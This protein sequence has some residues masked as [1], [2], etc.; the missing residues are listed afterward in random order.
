MDQ[1]RYGSSAEPLRL[2]FPPEWDPTLVSAVSLTVNDRDGDELKAAAN[3]TLWTA[4]TLDG[5]VAA[6]SETITLA[7]GADDLKKGDE[8]LLVGAGGQETVR[9]KGWDTSTKIATLEQVVKNAYDDGDNVYGKFGTYNLDISTVATYTNGIVLV[10]IWTPTGH[11]DALTTMVQV[12]K[13]SL[14]IAGLEREFSQ[15][16]ERA[17]KAFTNPENR[18][19]AIA[20]M[21][22]RKLGAWMDTKGLDIQRVVD[23]SV[24]IDALMIEMACLWTVNGDEKIEDERRFLYEER[25]RIYRTLEGRT[26]WTDTDMDQIEEAGELNPPKHRFRDGW[27]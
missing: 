20:K 10:F 9:V 7:A 2:E 6:F 24:L 8:I 3:I 21:A 13:T 26:F 19:A 1:L 22:E 25:E 16:Y 4:T 14:E 15:T 17:Y 18:F 5:A 12:A 11:G 27:W 23:Q